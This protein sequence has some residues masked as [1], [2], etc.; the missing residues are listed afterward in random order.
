M[1]KKM[2]YF[3]PDVELTLVSW[4]NNLLASTNVGTSSEDIQNVYSGSWDD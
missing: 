1:K 2:T 4:E 3:A